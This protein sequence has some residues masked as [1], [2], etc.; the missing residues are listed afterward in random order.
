MVRPSAFAVL[1]LIASTFWSAAVLVTRP[2]SIPSKSDR[3]MRLPFCTGRGPLPHRT[4]SRRID[5]VDLKH[6]LG[7]IQTD[8]DN[9][10]VDGS[11]CESWQRSPYGDSSPGAGAVHHIKTRNPRFIDEVYNTRRLHSALGY[12][13]PAQY[14]DRH[15]QQPVKAAA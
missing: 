5:A 6:V 7:D 1:R 14:E 4:S 12:L 9:L 13:T 15:A 3:R 8:C 10:H 11:L 2:L